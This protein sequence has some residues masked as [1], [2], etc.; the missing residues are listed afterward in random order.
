MKIGILTLPFHT[1]YGGILQAWALQTVL[2]RMGHEVKVLDRPWKNVKEPQWYKWIYLLPKRILRNL[3]KLENRTIFIERNI[4]Y[5][6]QVICQ[7]TNAFVNKYILSRKFN[8]FSE[9]SEREFEALV[10]GSDQV[11]RKWCF[12][13]NRIYQA[14]L[15]FAKGWSIK[16]IAY[17][18]SFGIDLWDYTEEQTIHCGE[19][20]RMFNAVSCREN[21]GVEFCKDHFNVKAE[22]VVDPTLLLRKDDY[23]ELIKNTNKSRGNLMCYVID[24]DEKKTEIVKQISKISGLTLFRAN[25][26]AEDRSGRFSLKDRIQPPVESWLKGFYD[27]E[28]VITDSFHACIFS[29]IFNKPFWV[30][31]N[32]DRGMSRF[33]SLLEMFDLESRL[34]DVNTENINFA[35]NINWEGINSKLE[36]LR[37]D[38]FVFLENALN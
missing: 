18:P 27:A 31:G 33:Y 17:A 14:Y 34:I 4:N 28:M 5:E 23:I 24:E 9:I 25:S 7:H 2:E 12:G 11:W 6:L 36:K 21:K 22:L 15:D 37:C 3:L 19:L 10:V 20:L 13:E 8:D 38:S 30:I 35:E 29:I 1:N 26:K 16:R 32:K